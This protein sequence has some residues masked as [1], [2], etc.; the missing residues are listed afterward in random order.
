MFGWSYDAEKHLTN[1]KTFN[2]NCRLFLFHGQSHHEHYRFPLRSVF[3]ELTRSNVSG[4][5]LP[6]LI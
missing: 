5:I 6:S 1:V 2:N 3:P 4:N